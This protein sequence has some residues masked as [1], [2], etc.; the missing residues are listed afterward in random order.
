MENRD[1]SVN[2]SS[3]RRRL[4]GHK[5][6]V[7]C[8][9]SNG[10]ILFSGSADK[11]VRV[12]DAVRMKNPYAQRCIIVDSQN[13]VSS[14]ACSASNPNQ[15]L[16]TAGIELFE[17]DTRMDNHV[18]IKHPLWR[19]RPVGAKTSNN[20]DPSIAPDLENEINS[21]RINP[22]TNSIV[23]ADDAGNIT[24][25]DAKQDKDRTS[26]IYTLKRHHESIVMRAEF[27]KRRRNELLSC[28]LDSRM[29]R[30]DILKRKPLEVYNL[31]EILSDKSVQYV[32]PPWICDI[33]EHDD[34][35]MVAAAL[36]NGDVCVIDTSTSQRASGNKNRK[37]SST[38]YESSTSKTVVHSYLGGAEYRGAVSSVKFVSNDIVSGGAGKSG[39]LCIWKYEAS[40]DKF[41]DKPVCRINLGKT[42]HEFCTLLPNQVSPLFFALNSKDI[43]VLNLHE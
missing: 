20:A 7:T 28:G 16:V 21:V 10:I 26:Q 39:T 42:V 3:S 19:A 2:F 23:L 36:Q 31:A 11:T 40:T 6:Q 43:S 41:S 33:S 9:C 35:R 17:F 37:K 22:A 14:V 34:G 29:I 38:L 1:H 25:I 8:V 24:F 12:W 5:K 32:N 18:L 27:R 4:V 30:W 13:A 15:I